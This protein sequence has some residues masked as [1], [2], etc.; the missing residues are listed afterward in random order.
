VLKGL[1]KWIYLNQ[2]DHEVFATQLTEFIELAHEL[3]TA[4]D[5]Y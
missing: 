2:T 5:D 3:Q 4:D 1:P